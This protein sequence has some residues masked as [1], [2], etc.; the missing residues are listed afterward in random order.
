MLLLPEPGVG[1]NLPSAGET[2]Q[3]W[4]RRTRTG[5]CIYGIVGGGGDVEHVVLCVIGQAHG[6]ERYIQASAA[7]GRISR[8]PSPS[9]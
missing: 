7:G 1:T 4:R 9:Q 6:R 5:Q 3:A 8:P 2:L